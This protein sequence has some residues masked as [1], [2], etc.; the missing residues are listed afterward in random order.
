MVSPRTFASVVLFVLSKVELIIYLEAST[1]FHA[2]ELGFRTT[3]VED[4]SR[5]IDKENISQTFDRIV[6]E[7]GCVV[8]SKA[9]TVSALLVIFPSSFIKPFL[10][11]KAMVQGKD[12]RPE[13]GWKLAVECRKKIS[14]PAKNKNSKF[15]NTTQA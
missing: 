1:A 6:E 12:R 8:N 14:Y 13:L 3:L 2:L 4:A 10:K 9:V 7:S 15:N 5:G 11:V